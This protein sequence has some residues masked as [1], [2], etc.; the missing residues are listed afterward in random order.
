MYHHVG[1]AD[2]TDSGSFFTDCE[3]FAQQ[4]DLIVEKYYP[5]TLSE[6]EDCYVNGKEM[7]RNA[8]LLTFDDGYSDNYTYAYPLLL[9]KKVPATVFLSTGHTGVAKN[10]LTWAQVKEMH[11]SRWI[12]FASHGVNHKRLRMCNDE[13]ILFEL[14]KSK[15][16]LEKALGKPVNSFCYPYGAFDK[17]V[18]RLV[19]KAGYIMDFGTRKG[20]N[21][22]PWKS[23]RPLL[24]AHVMRND[25]IKDFR[26]QLATGYKKGIITLLP[27]LSEL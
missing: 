22:W 20:I 6:L 7:P 24:R 23:R 9:K 11:E 13:D 21:S 27:G 25:S 1:R 5:V 18:R 16:V 19:F 17:R 14:A 3:T 8:V 4:L 12:E 2:D 26:R 15:E 10:M